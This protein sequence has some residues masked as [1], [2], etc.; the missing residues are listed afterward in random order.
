MCTCKGTEGG[1]PSARTSGPAS[2]LGGIPSVSNPSLSAR[3]QPSFSV[4]SNGKAAGPRAISASRRV[5]FEEAST[6]VADIDYILKADSATADRLHVIGMSAF[7]RVLT[8]VHVERGPRIRII[9]ARKATQHE[10][11]A[12]TRRR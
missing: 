12:Y 8:V 4:T 2:E 9:S 10:K 7:A 11:E 3:W 6:V 1:T 5:S